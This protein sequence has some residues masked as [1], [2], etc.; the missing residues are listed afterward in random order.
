VERCDEAW[1]AVPSG[2]T[3]TGAPVCAA[4]RT[5]LLSADAAD[6]FAV[7]SPTW[8]LGEIATTQTVFMLVRLALPSSTP[9][10]TVSGRS[11]SFGFGLFAEGDTVLSE[12]S[13]PS[14]AFTGVDA[15]SLALVAVG[16]IGTG[17][18]VSRRRREA[19]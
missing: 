11:A 8:S 12:V 5:T 6:D 1:T 3:S 15:L 18:V 16:A 2:V 9:A 13:S 10:A 14:L 17:L 7:A 4:G 19:S